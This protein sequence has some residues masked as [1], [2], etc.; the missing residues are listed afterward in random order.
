M[1]QWDSPAPPGRAIFYRY[2]RT[3][4][5]VA[6]LGVKCHAGEAKLQA[7]VGSASVTNK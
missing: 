2:G 5:R 4:D 6:L 7:G 3:G 1:E